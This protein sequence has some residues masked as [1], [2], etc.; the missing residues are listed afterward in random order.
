MVNVPSA[1]KYG[2]ELHLNEPVMRDVLNSSGVKRV[3]GETANT[4]RAGIVNH[5]QATAS[6]S[7][8]SNYVESMFQE[9]AF[10]DEYGFDFNG[11]YELGNR[12]IA[13]IGVP[14]G[15]GVDPTAKPPLMV[16]AETHALTSQLGVTVGG[17]TEDIR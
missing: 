10:S 11:P 9:D 2:F 5:V 1:R 6:P 17:I 7:S 14:A 16:E 12:P 4:M 15:R 13:V 8:A 3:L